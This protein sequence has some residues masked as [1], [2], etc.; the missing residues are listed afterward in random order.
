MQVTCNRTCRRT[1]PEKFYRLAPIGLDRITKEVTFVLEQQHK[2]NG[3]GNI[4][5]SEVY[6]QIKYTL[7]T[8]LH[9]FRQLSQQGSR[10]VYDNPSEA[11]FVSAVS[12]YR[13]SF[14]RHPIDQPFVILGKEVNTHSSFVVASLLGRLPHSS[15]RW[16]TNKSESMAQDLSSLAKLVSEFHKDPKGT[17]LKDTQEG[18]LILAWINQYRWLS[19]S[20]LDDGVALWRRLVLGDEIKSAGQ[21]AS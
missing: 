11:K 12:V 4:I 21:S 5:M 16:A 14:G 10:P 8:D 20:A 9:K 18:A 6:R 13:D 17:N 2:K 7:T 15:L 1:G 3:K 19:A